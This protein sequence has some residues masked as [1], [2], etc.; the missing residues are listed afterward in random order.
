MDG[1]APRIATVDRPALAGPP[2]SSRP[3]V[4]QVRQAAAGESTFYLRRHGAEEIVRRL[5]HHQEAVFELPREEKTLVGARAPQGPGY[6]LRDPDHQVFVVLRGGAPAGTTRAFVESNQWP[7]RPPGLI[8]VATRYLDAMYEL[9]MDVLR[10]IARGL[11]LHDEFFELFFGPHA[12]ENLQLHQYDRRQ[13]PA[14]PE[15][16]SSHVD[17]PAITLIAQ[18]EVGGLES[19]VAGGWVP[20]SPVPGT[21][22]VQF[23]EFL[24][25]WTNHRYPP[26]VH[27]VVN[28][29]VVRR[30]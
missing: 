5:Q 13:A 10:A 21:L 24:A 25:R 26:S 29:T 6:Q 18:D 17:P 14:R 8:D 2:G 20:V 19:L 30:T 3:A 28:S 23:G 9:S 16:L 1:G 11:D 7:A 4:E 15:F 22:V 27:R 12:I